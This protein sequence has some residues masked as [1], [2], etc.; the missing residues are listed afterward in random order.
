MNEVEVRGPPL[1]LRGDSDI[2]DSSRMDGPCHMQA[3]NKRS[4]CSMED[5]DSTNPVSG[6]QESLH[7]IILSIV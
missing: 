6:Q 1:S 3:S 7:S 4:L 5:I 2:G